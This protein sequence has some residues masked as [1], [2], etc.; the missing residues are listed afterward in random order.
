MDKCRAVVNVTAL[1]IYSEQGLLAESEYL[2]ALIDE[3]L[4]GM[5]V[6]LT[7]KWCGDYAEVLT[8]YRYTGY[9]HR[10]GLVMEQDAAAAVQYILQGW[11]LPAEDRTHIDGAWRWLKRNYRLKQSGQPGDMRLQ[12]VT[13]RLFVDVL[14]EKKVSSRVVCPGIPMGSLMLTS[15]Q[16]ENGWQAVVLPDGRSGYVPAAVISPL[17]AEPSSVPEDILRRRLTDTARTY[18]GCVY[19]WGGKSPV[20]VDCSGLCSMAYMM[21][22]IRIYRDASL[23]ETFPIHEITYEQLRE[24]DLI[25]F[26]GHI[27]M[28]LGDGQ[29]IHSTARAGDNGV[30]INSFRPEDA[31]YRADLPGMITACGSFFV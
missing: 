8:H 1:P 3:L 6:E 22:G 7:G 20:G 9:V 14:A 25:Y 24:G 31:N 11:Y 28:Y 5:S 29:Y 10:D 16:P 21:N 26:P 30:T 4:F 27:A 17:P 2:P 19:R 23:K 13:G 12:L 15:G 18:I